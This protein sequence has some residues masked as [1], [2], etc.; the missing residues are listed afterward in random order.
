MAGCRNCGST[1]IHGTKLVLSAHRPLSFDTRWR[2]DLQ[3]CAN[4]GLSDLFL[5]EK[6]RGWVKSHLPRIDGGKAANRPQS[7]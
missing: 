5:S 3:V 1:E 4:C 2:F 7:G 6:E